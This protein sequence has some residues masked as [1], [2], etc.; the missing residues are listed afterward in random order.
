ML[1]NMDNSQRFAVRL[2]I[3]LSIIAMLI[4]ASCSAGGG[5]VGPNQRAGAFF[6]GAIFNF[7]GPDSLDIDARAVAREVSNS[8]D[9]DFTP[10]GGFTLASGSAT[11]DSGDPLSDFAA[12]DGSISIS[13]STA[14]IELNVSSFNPQISNVQLVG[15]F[16]LI[17][18]QQAIDDPGSDFTVFWDLAYES[19]GLD[20]AI[21]YDQ[22]LTGTDLQ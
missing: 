16:S 11:S 1:V 10:G 14:T 5:P 8:R 7:A 3:A 20:V 2:I 4:L 17:E 6:G 21:S 13:G 22:T 18:A 19:D 9:Y 12:A 15:T